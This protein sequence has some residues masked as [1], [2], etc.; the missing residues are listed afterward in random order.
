MRIYGRFA[1]NYGANNTDN[2]LVG[3]QFNA[4]AL[5]FYKKAYDVFVL[6]A[7]QL[8]APIWSVVITTLSRV[9]QDMRQYQRYLLGA[10]G[11]VAFA[12]MGIGGAFTLVGRDLVRFLLGPQ[13]GQAGRIFQL[14]APGIGVMLLYGATGW[15]HVSI[16]RADRWLRWGLVELLL[17][18]A[19]FIA[20]LPLGPR[21][22][23]LAWTVAYCILVIPAFWYAG[24]P[25]GL[26]ARVVVA[27][28]W[29]F[30]AASVVACALAFAVIGALPLF[31]GAA[32]AA[33]ALGRA[34]WGTA[35][36]GALY[37]GTVAGLSRGLGPF[38]QTAALLAEFLPRRA[39]TV[40]AGM[41]PP[42]GWRENGQRD[43]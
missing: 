7:N 22:I 18:T 36:F 2:L 16:G 41:L 24:K 8:T 17:T 11:V 15:I 42:A 27:T 37:G 21:G 34:A 33:G 30:F 23:A 38:R 4:A 26:E 5:G 35:V 14:F 3:W 28:I 31:A 32:G 40:A 19:L 9:R 6:P 20:A 13:W 12:G 1:L 25:I 10:M 43:A 29:R 39:T